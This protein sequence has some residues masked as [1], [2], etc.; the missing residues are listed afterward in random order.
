MAYTQPIE[1]EFEI[2]KSGVRHKPTE[3][4]FSAYP[5]KPLQKIE[6]TGRLGSI[7]DDGRDYRQSDVEEMAQR[8]WM[9]KLEKR[10][11]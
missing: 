8:I 11:K 6:L 7:L 4:E 1:E 5:G 10:K 2:L 3:A 9:R